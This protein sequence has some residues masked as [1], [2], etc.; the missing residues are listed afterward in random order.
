MVRVRPGRAAFRAPAAQRSV[1]NTCCPPRSGSSSRR[2]KTTATRRSTRSRIP[3]RHRLRLHGRRRAALD[4]GQPAAARRRQPRRRLR[5][6]HLAR[7]R[8]LSERLGG[9]VR[10]SAQ[11]RVPGAFEDARRGHHPRL[12]RRREHPVP[13]LK[14]IEDA[15]PDVC[16]CARQYSL[17]DHASAVNELFPA[18]RKKGISLV[19]G[20]SLNAGFISGSP[21]YNYGKENFRIPAD[22]IDKRDQLRASPTATAS[23]CGRRPCSSPLRRTSPLHWWSGPAAISRSSRTGTRFRPGFP[24]SSGT[25]WGTK[26]SSRPARRC[27]SRLRIERPRCRRPTPIP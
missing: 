8:V 17:I 7:L 18:V 20:S 27:P 6:R 9:A 26:A 16:L 21:R 19:I 2:R 4:R 22:V 5:A 15:D 3:Q 13:I 1:A 14:V 24:Q 11:G 25:T 23:T 12:G 10:N